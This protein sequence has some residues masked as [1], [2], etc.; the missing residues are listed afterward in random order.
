MTIF[1]PQ[2][3]ELLKTAVIT[4]SGFKSISPSDC[5]VISINIQENT[6][7]SVSETTLKRVFGFAYSK[8]RP[9][10]FTIDAMSQYCGYDGWDDFCVKQKSRQAS[11]AAAN[12]NWIT[13]MQNAGKI[14]SFTLQTLKNKSGI[15]Y[16]QTIKREFIKSHLDAFLQ[17]EDTATVV[18]APAGY[19]KTL[20][21]CHWIEDT[22]NN[23]AAGIS[24]DVVLFFS[25]SALMSVFFSGRDLNHWLLGL[26]GYSNDQDIRS[27]VDGGEKNQ[28]RFYLII[29]GLDEFTYKTDQ[30]QLLLQQLSDVFSLYQSVLWFKL[31]VTMRSATWVNHKHELSTDNNKWFTN[32][33]EDKTNPALNVPLFSLPE[34]KELCF[35]INPAIQNFLAL[36]LT[37]TFN[38]PLYFQFYY[39]EYKDNFSLTN[40]D[41]VCIYDL[42]S[43]FVLNKVYLGHYSADKLSLLNALIEEMDFIT[44][45]FDIEK[46]KVN[47]LLKQYSHAYNELLSVGFLRE[48]NT[49]S[50]MQ[51]NT[52][53]QFTNTN[54]LDFTIAKH[55]LLKNDHKFDSHLIDVINKN[56]ANS[57]RKLFV[58]KWCVNYAIKTG[59]QKSFELLSLT[60]LSPGEKSDLLIF[61]GELLD[62][63]AYP[64]NRTE[65]I[66]LYFKQDCNE[67][68]FNYFFGLELLTVDYKKTL[69]TLLKFELRN[70]KRILVYTAL[71]VIAIFQ[72]DMD[73]VGDYISKLKSI[74]QEDYNSFGINPLESLEALHEF[75]KNGII[76]RSH[77]TKLTKFYFNPPAHGV[78][79]TQNSSTELIFILGAYSLLLCRN[80]HKILR[81]MN[82]VKNTYKTDSSSS[83]IYLFFSEIILAN[84]YF[85][86]N[87]TGDAEASY[88]SITNLYANSDGSFTAFMK[89][90]Y[91]ALKIKIAVLNDDY[92]EV[93][94]L[95]KTLDAIGIESNNRLS[96]VFVY[97]FILSNKYIARAH[98]QLYKEVSLSF[99]NLMREAGLNPEIMFHPVVYR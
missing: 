49:S 60:K 39:K 48:F 85:I 29:D 23:N 71:S 21:L 8:F 12:V 76:K 95:I 96:R 63:A 86:L 51:Y 91:Y 87:R 53:M 58:L 44:N 78:G 20:A 70:H 88:A 64:V 5:R 97:L 36:D 47:S 13:L 55:L 30:F 54:F 73:S 57:P 41:H 89:A 14:T 82:A 16:N 50:G 6:R 31:I 84:S 22:L 19:G 7:H 61:L 98:A 90:L 74:P 56:F 27:L 10:L 37:E 32:F 68:L 81:F 80:P 52:Y 77:F 72:L 59:Q 11:T 15:P 18:T 2:Y 40:M 35:K 28:G 79:P 42:I 67:D 33:I 94:T 9:S 92:E 69:Q 75:F 83:P 43:T 4:K 65:S 93:S 45:R 46:L 38:H 66:Y 17:S 24:N 1:L 34:I 99:N 62:K 25:S 26:L 3:F